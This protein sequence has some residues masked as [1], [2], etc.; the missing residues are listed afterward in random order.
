MKLHEAFLHFDQLW[1]HTT[2]VCLLVLSIR[3]LQD[4]S[5]LS[6]GEATNHTWLH[7]I[8][9]GGFKCL[10][11]LVA[12]CFHLFYFC[13]CTNEGGT[14]SLNMVDQL[15]DH[16][17][18]HVNCTSWILA[19]FLG[20]PFWVSL[21]EGWFFSRNFRR[22]IFEKPPDLGLSTCAVPSKRGSAGAQIFI[23]FAQPASLVDHHCS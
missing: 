9:A 14:R 1:F 16:H 2:I 4:I 5:H 8:L 23:H 11:I 10:Q 22:W 12:S 15:V 13:W 21:K 19:L 17:I 18:S 3:I 20:T 6:W 7:H